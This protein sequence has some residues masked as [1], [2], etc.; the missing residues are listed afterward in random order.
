MTHAAPTCDYY[1]DGLVHAHEW[2]RSTPPGCH[3]LADRRNGTPTTSGNSEYDA[4]S[5]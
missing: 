2:A 4:G 5:E 3:H 1:D